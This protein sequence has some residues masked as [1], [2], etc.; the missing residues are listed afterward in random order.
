MKTINKD[1][2]YTEEW[3]DSS[4][5]LFAPQTLYLYAH[6]PE[7]RSV[8]CAN[9]L[10]ANNPDTTFVELEIDDE[11]IMKIKGGSM[12]V[13]LSSIN[14]IKAFFEG[15]QPAKVYV[16]VTGMSC[17]MAAPLLK[18]A[19][20]EGLDI[21]VVYIE[22]D[23]Y[24][25]PEFENEGIN[26][27][28]SECVEGVKS[29]PG[30]TKLFRRFKTEPLF[31]V[32]L[33]FEGG[34]FTYMIS[35]QQPPYESIRPIIGVPGYR[36]EYPFVSYWGNRFSLKSTRAWERVEY[37]EAN[38]IVDS[39]F[40]LDKIWQEN[41]RPDMIIA[42]IGTKPHAIGAILYA[43]KNDARVELIY[44]NPKRSV[45]RTQGIGK[46]LVCNVSKLYNEN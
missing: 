40:T 33:G 37:A 7:D 5:V 45:H 28:L 43:I 15:F 14:Q 36:M 39:F 27:D 2:L 25:L 17:R 1:Y 20:L 38:S 22:P 26:S 11:D 13:N 24:K 4:A 16:E 41:H 23:V 18:Y 12:Q 3:G 21:S 35:N 10:K 30:F 31:V 9:I 6:D 8:F 42:P 44:D 19:I 46:V 29:L 34:R 32:L